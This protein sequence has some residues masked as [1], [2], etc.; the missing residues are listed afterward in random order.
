[1][2]S[3]DRKWLVVYTKPLNEK[4]VFERL[5]ERG[6]E[7]YLPLKEEMRQWSDRKKKIQTPLI[8]RV[9][10][11]RMNRAKIPLLYEVNGVK[12]VLK[13]LGKPAFVQEWEIFNLK[14]LL[15]E[16][17]WEEIDCYAASLGDWVIIAAGP[18]KGAM[19]RVF[20]AQNE[21]RVCL[22]L[23]NVGKGFVVSVPQHLLRLK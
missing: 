3:E 8:S 19:G 22:T 23:E 11:V 20:L 14:L 15:Q 7:A 12:N 18:F 5:V 13:H 6:I 21:S 9:V 17:V 1:M 10:F 16:Q 2:T 4:K